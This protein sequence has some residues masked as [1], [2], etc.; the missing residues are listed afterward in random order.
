MSGHIKRFWMRLDRRLI[1]L[2][3]LAVLPINLLAI[4]FCSVA[5]RESQEKVRLARSRE[6]TVL[7]SQEMAKLQS[8]R[9]WYADFVQSNLDRLLLP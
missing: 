6:F 4:W 9:Q 1:A 3:C 7:V 5:V 8:A 2:I